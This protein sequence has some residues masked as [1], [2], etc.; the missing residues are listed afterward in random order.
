MAKNLPQ[1]QRVAAYGLVLRD[2]RILLTRLARRIS[3]GE[4]W[5]LP[6]GGVDHGEDHRIPKNRGA[7]TQSGAG[8]GERE[9]GPS[10]NGGSRRKVGEEQAPRDDKR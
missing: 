1:V 3:A 5:H 10:G 7:R 6:G 4:R 9:S 2:N 8:H